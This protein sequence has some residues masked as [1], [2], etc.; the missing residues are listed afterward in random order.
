MKKKFRKFFSVELTLAPGISGSAAAYEELK[1]Y[2]MSIKSRGFNFHHWMFELFRPKKKLCARNHVAVIGGQ[3]VPR[4][5][6]SLLL[7]VSLARSLSL[8]D[9]HLDRGLSLCAIIAFD[10]S[11]EAMYTRLNISQILKRTIRRVTYTNFI[12]HIHFLNRGFNI[13]KC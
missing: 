8:M 10:K 2:Y 12:M 9:R 6:C 4:A 5:L 7:S 13:V 1:Y 11:I 3:L